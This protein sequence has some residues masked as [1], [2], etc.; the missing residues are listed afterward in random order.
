MR[1]RRV[2][3]GLAL[4]VALSTISPALGGPSPTAMMAA[5]V[6]KIAKKA[7]GESRKA[8]RQAK[9]AKQLGKQNAALIAELEA[10]VG[11]Q[12]PQGAPGQDATNLFAYVRDNGSANTA[13]L[14]YG[15]GATG[16]SD[17][18]GHNSAVGPYVVAFDRD[19]S[20]CVAHMTTGFGDPVAPPG[21]GGGQSASPA[22][23]SATVEGSTVE[24]Y[25]YSIADLSVPQD[26][27]FMV[28]V[29]C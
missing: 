19:L 29:F 20:G 21:G 16:V 6:K 10:T 14:Q 28:S 18:P 22:S 15:Q 5:S 4:V 2:L 25:S 12:G 17:P 9:R 1:R 11:P 8:K 27:S 13:V 7:L 24:T 3:I 23:V 26:N